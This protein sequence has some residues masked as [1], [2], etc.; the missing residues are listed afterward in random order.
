ML[1]FYSS[2]PIV[3][4]VVTWPVK[5]PRDQDSRILA[6]WL[7]SSMN[8]LQLLLNR[9]ETRGAFLE[10]SK[11]MLERFLILDP[12]NLSEI[13][14]NSLL[15]VFEKVKDATFPSILDQLNERFPLRVE[16]DKAVLKVLGFGDEEANRILDYLHPALA[17]EIRQ[18]KT[19]MQG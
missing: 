3:A 7:N 15:Q 14:K 12:K 6:V 18:L 8:I 2:V 4:A 1:A 5:I 10:I 19:L 16:I 13:E 17:N 11:Y 9:S